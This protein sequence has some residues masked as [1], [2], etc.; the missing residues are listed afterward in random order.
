MTIYKNMVIYMF[1]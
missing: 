1:P